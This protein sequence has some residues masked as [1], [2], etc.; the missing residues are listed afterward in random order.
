[1]DDI[2]ILTADAVMQPDEK[3]FIGK[4]DDIPPAEWNPQ[5]VCNFLRQLRGGRACEEFDI[6]IE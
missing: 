1:L 3:I 4:F 2:A 6:P 5:V